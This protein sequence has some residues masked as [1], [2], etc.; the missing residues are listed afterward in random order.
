MDSGHETLDNTKLPSASDT[1]KDT[2]VVVNDLGQGG[3][4]VGGARGVRDDV[5]FRL[6]RVEVDTT[7]KPIDELDHFF[8]DV[9]W[10]IGR[11]SRDDDLFGTTLQVE[12]SLFNGGKHTSRLDNVL[13]T[14]LSPLD[15]GRVS[16]AI[17]D[18]GLVVDEELALLLLN[19]SL[20]STVHRVVLEHVDL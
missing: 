16:L 9:H 17:D 15:V 7:D 11:G 8:L 4:T 1:P 3:K 20:E 10:R 12:T 6:V 18:D 5:V 13:C 2:Y 14:G 19:G